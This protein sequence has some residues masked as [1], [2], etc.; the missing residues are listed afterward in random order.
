MAFAPPRPQ[1]I[2][3]RGAPPSPQI[4]WRLGA[5]VGPNIGSGIQSAMQSLSKGFVKFQEAKLKK[6]N[7]EGAEKSLVGMGASPED[8]K[9]FAKYPEVTHA[10]QTIKLAGEKAENENKRLAAADQLAAAKHAMAQSAH[11]LK[12][13]ERALEI[14]PDIFSKGPQGNVVMNKEAFGKLSPDV[15][16]AINRLSDETI[17]NAEN[18][19]Q[20]GASFMLKAKSGNL[21]AEELTPEEVDYAKGV[22]PKLMNAYLGWNQFTVETNVDN[23]KIPKGTAFIIGGNGQFLGQSKDLSGKI[24]RWVEDMKKIDPGYELTEADIRNLYSFNL[25]RVDLRDLSNLMTIHWSDPSKRPLL[26]N[27]VKSLGGGGGTPTPG[28]T[29]PPVLDP[30]RVTQP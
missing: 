12:L 6:A 29:P 4:D 24:D 9:A 25:D 13:D 16:R 30:T 20:A 3:G 14:A 23:P 17:L 5:Q 26:I 8:A 2:F 11:D 18:R 10:Y 22:P 7:Q 15:Q 19:R 28:G 21:K 1:S 27:L